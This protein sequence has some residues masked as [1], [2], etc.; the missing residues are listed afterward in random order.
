MMM[1]MMIIISSSIMDDSS[2][3]SRLEQC[4]YTT[5][6]TFLHFSRLGSNG[7]HSLDTLV[8][9]NLPACPMKLLIHKGTCP[10]R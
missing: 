9:M 1:M 6:G 3:C 8:L 10:F 4:I 2:S 5:H 7:S